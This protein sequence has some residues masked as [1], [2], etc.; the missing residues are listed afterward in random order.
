MDGP[1]AAAAE[2]W[3]SVET[4]P[5]GVV[6]RFSRALSIIYSD[7]EAVAADFGI[8]L[9]TLEALAALRLAPPPHRLSQ[10]DVG[11]LL[12][13]T[14]GTLS[15]RLARLE[16]GGLIS[17]EP[18]P[19]DARGVIVQLTPR[20]RELVDAAVAARF[21]AESKLLS[22]LGRQEQ[23]QLRGLLRKLLVSLE[24]RETGPRLGLEIAPR[25]AARKLRSDHGIA[26]GVGLLVSAVDAGG[27]AHQAGIAAGDLALRLDGIQLRSTA[28]LKRGLLARSHGSKLALTLLREGK[29]LLVTVRVPPRDAPVLHPETQATPKPI[30]SARRAP[31]RR[32]APVR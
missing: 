9:A 27:L 5:H 28:Q 2:I 14:S 31:A 1:I 22:A 10:R 15:V 19:D 26:D 23:E 29:E 17:R 13:R 11:E 32:R 30:R 20:G 18:D 4:L 6:V 16:Q 25:R 7:L 21:E 12:M 3:P 8:S 24:Q